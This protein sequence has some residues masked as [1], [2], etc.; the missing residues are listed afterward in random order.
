MPLTVTGP[1]IT[2]SKH[3]HMREEIEFLK[4]HACFQA[5]IMDKLTMLLAFFA[6]CHLDAIHFNGAERW[7]FKKVDAAQQRA[8]A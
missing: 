4:D 5:D 3:A 7:F 6:A 2:F 8:F 1:S